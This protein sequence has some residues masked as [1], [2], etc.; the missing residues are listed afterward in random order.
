MNSNLTGHFTEEDLSLALETLE[1]HEEKE[2]Y[3]YAF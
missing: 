2:K 1:T 3:R